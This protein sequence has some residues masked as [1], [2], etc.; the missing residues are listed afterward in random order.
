MAFSVRGFVREAEAGLWPRQRRGSDKV[1][2]WPIHVPWH[3][4]RGNLTNWKLSVLSL[5]LSL[6][7]SLFLR[8]TQLSV[9]SPYLSIYLFPSLYLSHSLSPVKSR[10]TLN[11]KFET[12]S[13]TLQLTGLAVWHIFRAVNTTSRP[14][15]DRQL[16]WSSHLPAWNLLWTDSLGKQ[17]NTP[18]NN[19]KYQQQLIRSY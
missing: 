12:N 16:A 3:H 7:L 11:M 15:Q 18:K 2:H 9:L 5:F 1:S 4:H 8:Q 19:T 13:P 17:P 6:S 14:K 10:L